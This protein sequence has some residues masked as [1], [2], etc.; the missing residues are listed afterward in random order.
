M[1]SQVRA[2]RIPFESEIPWVTRSSDMGRQGPENGKL[3]LRQPSSWSFA[4]FGEAG[5]VRIVDVKARRRCDTEDSIMEEEKRRDRRSCR[6]PGGAGGFSAY[7][8]TSRPSALEV[9]LQAQD[10][11]TQERAS[12]RADAKIISHSQEQCCHRFVLLG[13]HSNQRFHGIRE[14]RTWGDRAL[15]M[16]NYFCVSP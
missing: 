11:L 5:S 9:S 7:P 3:F 13:P 6:F 4:I 1:L 10:L 2:S 14:V 12:V 8:R 15:R 16:G